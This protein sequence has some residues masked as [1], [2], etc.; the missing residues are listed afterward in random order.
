MLSYRL[1][2]SS[3]L[4]TL[5]AWKRNFS[6]LYIQ[7]LFFHQDCRARYLISLTPT[8]TF[9]CFYFTVT[10]SAAPNDIATDHPLSSPI[11]FVT[12]HLLWLLEEIWPSFS[13]YN[14]KDSLSARQTDNSIYYICCF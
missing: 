2:F 10:V 3:V 12:Y 6:L 1:V 11:W 8:I 9:L 13:D 4:T 7:G 14:T 5:W